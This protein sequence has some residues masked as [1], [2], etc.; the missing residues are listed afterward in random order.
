MKTVAII[1]GGAAG[2]ACA[3]ELRHLA[4]QSGSAVNIVVYESTDKVGRSILQSGNG[5]CNF[6]NRNVVP[7]V[8]WNS[9]FVRS[10]LDAFEQGSKH[11]SEHINGVV[12]F[13]ERLGLLWREEPDGRLYPLANKAAVVL[14]VLKGPLNSQVSHDVSVTIK[15]ESFV[16]SID[17]PQSGLGHFTLRMRSGEFQRADMVVVACGGHVAS[18]LLPPEV[19]FREMHPILCPIECEGKLARS[20]ENVRVKCIASLLREGNCIA[21]ERGE[22]MFRKYGL[23]G[24]AIFNLSRDADRGDIVSLDLIPDVDE[25]D[26]ARTLKRRAEDLDVEY[27]EDLTNELFMNGME[28]DLVNNAILSVCGLNPTARFIPESVDSI[29]RTLKDFTFV[30]EGMADTSH[31]QCHRG[32]FAVEDFDPITMMSNDIAGLFLTGEALD[33]DGP[34]GG[35]NL[36]WAF[37]TGILAARDIASRL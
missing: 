5:R 18:K 12:S 23:S 16:E 14:D 36:H 10:A 19:S 13:F 25:D 7:A 15:T 17:P 20:M 6:S 28:A 37:S 11:D 21:V 9:E 34:C 31:A 26:L 35:Y 29:V 22:V 1:G 4:A 2:L 27:E 8:Y 24:I 32:G 30:V 3:V 33:V